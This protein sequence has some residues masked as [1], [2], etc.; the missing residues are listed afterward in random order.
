MKTKKILETERLV[1]RELN[2]ND[3]VFILKLLNTPTWL[4]FIGDKKVHTIEDAKNYL[5]KGPIDSYKKNGFG[6]WL[7]ILKKDNAPI[8]MCGLINRESLD[9]IDIG[10]ALLPEHEKLGYGFEVASATMNYARNVLGINKIVAIT[11]PRNIASIKLLN[12]MGLQFEKTIKVA[13]HDTTL[14]FSPLN[15]KNNRIEIDRLTKRFFGLFTNTKG[16][17]PNVND[18]KDIFVS[19]G[20]LINNTED[21]PEV[22][23]LKK[24]IEPRQKMLTDGTLTNFIEREI[25]AKTEIF[26]KIAQRFS[27]YEKSGKLNGEYFTTKGMKTIQFI[28]VN[29]EW[30]MSSVAWCDEK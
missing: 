28:K 3:A 13:E 23:D 21:T 27:L 26:E 1:L 6:L 14:L 9:D 12:K 2:T 17:T 20:M 10:F 7:I 30:K 5:V 8:G 11:D 4:K 25:F 19:K 16:K 15:V 29:N 18:I 22:F 24:F